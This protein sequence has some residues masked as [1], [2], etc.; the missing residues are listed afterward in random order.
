MSL[1][2]GIFFTFLTQA[3]T[4]L[5][6]FVS[7]TLMTRMLGDEGRGAYALFTNQI[8]LFSM[9]LSVNIGFGIT[10]FTSR[11]GP[12]RSVIGTGVTMLL[13]NLLL[14][15]VVLW[16]VY[17]VPVLDRVMMPVG[18]THWAYRVF[19]F[20]SI[21]L[22]LF[23][24][25]VSAVM[26][27]LKKFKALNWMS[28]VNA[29]LSAGGFGTLY[30]LRHTLDPQQVLPAV[31]G[32][33][34]FVLVT[35]TILW[36]VIYAIHVGIP[37]MPTLSW[38]VLK[39]IVA[40]SLVGHL[41]NLINLINYR[42]DVWVVDQYH[43]AANLGIYV[44]G[45]GVAQLLFYI[46]EPFSRVVQPYL[47]GQE[48][49]EMIA[50]FKAVSRLNFTS[51][52]V[53]GLI[54]GILAQWFIPLL[55]GPVFSGSVVAL[56]YLLPG[57]LFS[58]TSKLLAQLVVQG[59][60]QKYNLLGTSVAAVVTIVLDLLLIPRWGIVG[61]AVASSLAYLTILLVMLYTIRHRLGIPLNDMF[62]VKRSDLRRLRI[63]RPW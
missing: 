61:A 45:V 32:V 23:N 28:I 18:A 3:P 33:T 53:L 24:A 43:G 19:I 46:P 36:C 26:L 30:L 15:P 44:V 39:P 21:I 8:A 49:S 22:S 38:T 13:I 20:V 52:L 34:L 25:S 5:L 41:S 40:F 9:L 60:Y 54:M 10:Y 62:L 59:G 2:R 1:N 7:S 35:L 51:V 48:R 37:P 29:A 42:F 47:F 12:E 14:V 16:A 50:R 55:F 56:R 17:A 57:I 11:S 58:G 4:L 27:G 31:L 63:E 6:F